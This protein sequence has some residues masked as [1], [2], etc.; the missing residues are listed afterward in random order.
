MGLFD[1]LAGAF[2]NDTDLEG[3]KEGG[4]KNAAKTVIGTYNGK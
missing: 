1:G 3:R 4:F 2:A